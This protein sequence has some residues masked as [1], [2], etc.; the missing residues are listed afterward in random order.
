MNYKFE[1][2]S[3]EENLF[4]K[5]TLRFVVET[6]FVY[7]SIYVYYKLIKPLHLEKQTIFKNRENFV[8]KVANCQKIIMITF[9]AY[10]YSSVLN[11]DNIF[12]KF[13]YRGNVSITDKGYWRQYKICLPPFNWSM[14]RGLD[15]ETERIFWKQPENMRHFLDTNSSY[16]CGIIRVVANGIVS[17]PFSQLTNI[18][19]FKNTI[20]PPK[21]STNTDYESLVILT[22][23]WG[24]YFQHFFDNIG[25]QL[26]L[27]HRL[28]GNQIE[29]YPVLVDLDTKLFPRVAQ[30]WQ[31]L[32]FRKV[33]KSERG[34]WYSANNL[35]YIESCPIVHPEFFK[36]LREM[37][38]LP[39]FQ[40]KYVI[41]CG[42]SIKSTYY[43]Q[44]YIKNQDL[45]LELL[46][47]KYGEDLIVYDHTK[48]DLNE[49]I[50]LFSK[51]KLIIGPHGGAMYNQFFS[52]TETYVVEIMPVKSNGLYP[53]Q[54][55]RREKPTFSHMSVWSNTQLIGQTFYRYYQVTK[56]TNFEVDLA[57]FSKFLDKVNADME[58]DNNI[59]KDE[60]ENRFRND[61][62]GNIFKNDEPENRFGT[63]L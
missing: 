35:I 46:E 26:S 47:E 58:S 7:C 21:K 34:D 3:P 60:P 61:E 36:D 41:Y 54:N 13:K 57:K 4:D 5:K 15:A 38:S 14:P 24:H 56:D 55:T 6:L 49:T 45:L 52:S 8:C 23:H 28:L 31:K 2:K 63:D 30:L 22:G 18:T 25:P 37:L 42:R 39:A 12:P 40:H 44:R 50:L 20:N 17:Q 59:R 9:L 51:A 10:F 1:S 43:Q 62:H 32:P 33:I 11:Q 53:D 48:Y 29:Y 16:H 27:M 19:H